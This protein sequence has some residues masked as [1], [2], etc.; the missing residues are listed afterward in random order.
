MSS[1]VRHSLYALLA[2]TAT[3]APS[4]ASAQDAG[5]WDR[6]RA[7]LVAQQPGAMAGEI[8]RWERLWEDSRR[9]SGGEPDPQ[10]SFTEYAGFLATNP[11][12]PD[13]EAL[14]ASA[15]AAAAR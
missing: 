9:R 2:A 8:A 5:E 11:G 15:E 10:I 14:R 12:F 6:N 3:I 13:E 7:S 4:I 1:M